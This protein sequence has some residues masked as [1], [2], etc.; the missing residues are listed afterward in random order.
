MFLNVSSF[1]PKIIIKL[2]LSVKG[3]AWSVL[4]SY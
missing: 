2:F 4:M 1:E 3:V